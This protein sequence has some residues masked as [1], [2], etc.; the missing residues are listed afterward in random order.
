MGKGANADQS[1]FGEA[2]DRSSWRCIR[3]TLEKAPGNWVRNVMSCLETSKM[4]V[5]WNGK[6]LEWLKPIR[7][8]RQGDVISSYLFVLCMERLRHI[9]RQAVSVEI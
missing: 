4:S 7:E 6:R 1:G 2:Y 3:D 9:I 5:L 8:I